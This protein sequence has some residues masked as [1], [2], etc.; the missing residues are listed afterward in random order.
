VATIGLSP[1]YNLSAITWRVDVNPRL[2]AISGPLKDSSFYIPPGEV[3]IGRDPANRLAIADPSL[4][5]RHCLIFRSE[6]SFTIRD[7]DSRNGTFVNGVAVKDSELV[8][9]DQIAIGD[10]VFQLFAREE[11][12][13]DWGTRV[14]FDD[15]MTQATAQFRPQDVLY[16]HPDRILRELPAN[17]RLAR[18]LNALLKISRV[19]HALRD[20]EELQLQILEL[21]FEIVPAERGAVLLDPKGD[22]FS[23]VFAR[24]RTASAVHPVRVSRTI[25]RQVLEEGLAILSSDL[26][27]LNQFAGVE[28]LV[29]SNV[30]SLLCVPLSVF[31]KVIGCI[32]LDTTNPATRFDED[33]LQLVAAI[34]N[35]CAVALDNARNLH[36]LEQENLRLKTEINLE[37]NMV[38]D[39]AKIKD[40]FL[41]LQ[42]VAPTEATVLLRGE[43]GT[44]KELA[45]RAIHRN[46]PRAGKPFV[47]INCGAIPEGLVESELFGHERGSFTGAIAQKKGKLEIADGGVVFL[48]EVGEL[49]LA[50]QVKLLRV[51]QEREIERVGGTRRIPVNIRLI[52][53]TNKDLEQ[54]V[55]EKQFR[56]DLYFRL[57]VISL[58][59]PSLRERREDIPTLAEY[60][61]RK[62]SSEAAVPAKRISPEAMERLLQYEWPGN[63]RELENAFERAVVMSTSDVIGVDDLP[64]SLLQRASPGGAANPKYHDAILELKKQLIVNAIQ[65][66]G[67][68]YTEAAH[69][70][71]VHP[72][73]LHRLIKNLGL[74]ESLKS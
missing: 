74:K 11:D 24:H 41:R 66:A 57:N 30:R 54:A 32:Y 50:V 1:L 21:I 19:V 67:G 18:N 14:E 42:R 39:G 58:V 40:I 29:V 56:Q 61:S 28:S 70:L 27:G 3:P 45:A 47:P 48:D 68:N 63:V 13:T 16:L 26:L 34:A 53:A 12:G 10:S 15:G 38:G 60:F 55:A 65:E 7:L 49:P 71:G 22:G 17:S 59:M 52:A 20:L 73:Y 35:I 6:D 4:S 43:S 31:K 33:N 69:A 9:R 23:S 25:T 62:Y 46:S 37:H 51:L 2:F 36:W 72:N 5:R 44:G 8:H 64:D